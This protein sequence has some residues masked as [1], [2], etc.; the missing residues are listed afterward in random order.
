MTPFLLMLVVSSAAMHP[1]REFF[2][3]G[4]A[5]PEGVTLA[6]NI[7]F[8]ILAAAHVLA[9]G[10]NPM[11]AFEVWPMMLISGTGLLFYYWCVVATM[12]SGDLSIYYPITRSSPLFVVSVGYLFLGHQY[13]TLM[14]CGIALVLIG[15]FL[16]QY[17]WGSHLFAEPRTLFLATLAMCGHGVITLVDAEAMKHVEPAVFIF[18]LYIYVIPGMA[19]VQSLTCPPGRSIYTHLIAGWFETP[20]RFAVAGITSYASY[21]LILLAFQLGANVAAVSAIRQV[22][23]PMSVLMGCLILK[24]ER[25][26]ARLAW[27]LVLAVGVAI[28]VVAK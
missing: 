17:R 21:Y 2:I 9:T 5:S 7:W 6:V 3:K 25:M 19:I 1:L 8:W 12:K 10:M 20:I 14:L 13:S 15:A 16:L 26:S 28:I 27:S 23:I 18:V 11:D 22:S 4:D 24:E